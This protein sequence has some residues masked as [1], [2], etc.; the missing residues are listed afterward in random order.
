MI[1]GELLERVYRSIHADIVDGVATGGT[2]TTIV[3]SSL[4]GRYQENKFK[5]WIAFIS[6]TTDGLSPQ[7]KYGI[8]ASYTNAG[9]ATIPSVTDSVQAGDEYA[10]CK[11]D[12][13][14]HTLRK[15]C[16]DALQGLGRIPLIDT[17]LT[18]DADT[19]RYTLPLAIKGRKP[20]RVFFRDPTTKV[21]AHP[22]NYEIEP[23]EPGTQATLVFKKQFLTTT[24]SV[25]SFYH[26]WTIVVYYEDIHPQ[27][28]DYDDPVS[29][30]I[31]ENLAVA[32]CVEKA[33]MWKVYPRQRK[34]DKENWLLAKQSLDEAKREYP[35]ERPTRERQYVPIGIFNR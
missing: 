11:P 26:G 12:V 32:A 15:L 14:L 18:V 16:N 20:S 5:N 29:E 7:S 13:P 30:T 6:R 4:A 19:V 21:I 17:S 1:F 3:D 8:I 34:T 24:G 25:F 35:L 10:F 9:T 33:M 31:H 27:L 22:P 28:T 23:A 2:A